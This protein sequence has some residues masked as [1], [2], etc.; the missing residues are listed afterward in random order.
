M[1]KLTIRMLIFLLLVPFAHL[2]DIW[3]E[4]KPI[5]ERFNKKV[6]NKINKWY[7]AKR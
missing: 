2:V 5:N 4:R 6:N 1:I 7:L 3:R